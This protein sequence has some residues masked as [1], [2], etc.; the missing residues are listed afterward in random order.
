MAKQLRLDK[1]LCEQGVGSRSEVKIFLKKG[2]VMVNGVICKNA[3]QKIDPESDMIAYQ[4]KVFCYQQY[5]YYMLHKPAGVITATEDSNQKTVMELMGEDWRKDLFP[6]GR[7]DKDTEGLLLITNDGELSHALLSP[8]K[9]VPKTYLVQIPER[10]NAEQIQKLEEGVDIGD[11]KLTM[12]A[13]VQKVDDE[14][15]LLTIK[16]GRYHQVKRMLATVGSQV[17]YLKRITF[18]AL[19]LDEVLE[20]G[21]YRALTEDEIVQLRQKA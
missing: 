11:E 5:Y 6:V 19:V 21:A 9:H 3:D 10:L 17:L 20:K 2:Q 7:L 12:P 4:G 18:G 13:E 8:K 15:I 16:E 14:H 1:F